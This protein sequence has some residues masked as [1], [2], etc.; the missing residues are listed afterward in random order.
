MEGDPTEKRRR[1]LLEL[2]KVGRKSAHRICQ[3]SKSWGGEQNWGKGEKNREMLYFEGKR[4][5][6]STQCGG[7][8]TL[9]RGF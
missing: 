6:E 8:E 3:T 5:R 1:T 7:E 4:G 2:P 9:G